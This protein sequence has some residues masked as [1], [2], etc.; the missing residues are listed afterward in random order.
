[1]AARISN[2]I[3]LATKSVIPINSPNV[4]TI[5]NSHTPSLTIKAAA[6]MSTK[7]PKIKPTNNIINKSWARHRNI[8][9]CSDK[10]GQAILSTIVF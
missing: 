7:E 4:S 10:Y 8:L 6:A 1:M 9:S 2:R 3:C 5:A